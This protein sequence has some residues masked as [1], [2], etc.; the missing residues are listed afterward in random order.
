VPNIIA[1]EKDDVDDRPTKRVKREEPALAIKPLGVVRPAGVV[2]TTPFRKDSSATTTTV[3]ATPVISNQPSKGSL[4]QIIEQAMEDARRAREEQLA[5]EA[6]T[7]AEE[8]RLAEE[9]ALRK[10]KAKEKS[11]KHKRH[12]DKGKDSKSSSKPH[13]RVHDAQENGASSSRGA[14]KTMSNKEKQLHKLVGAA[15]VGYL[16]QFRSSFESSDVFKEHAKK[17]SIE[18]IKLSDT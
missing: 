1:A 14:E 16:S 18:T 9:K 15:V 11:D 4:S 6:A 7:A 13:S 12:K 2:A 17:V 3:P 10:Q 5:K 8:K